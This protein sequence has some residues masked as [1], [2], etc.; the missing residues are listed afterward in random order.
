MA[1]ILDADTTLQHSAINEACD[2]DCHELHNEQVSEGDSDCDV[3]DGPDDGCPNAESDSEEPVEDNEEDSL[4]FEAIQKIERLALSFLEQLAGSLR[5]PRADI[6]YTRSSPAA[7]NTRL[8]YSKIELQLADRHKTSS[9]C[10]R[11]IRYPLKRRGA[12][13]KPFGWSGSRFMTASFSPN[14]RSNIAQ[15]LRVMDFAHQAL[16]DNVPLTKRDMYYKDV[17]LFKAQGTV[18]RLVDDLAV[19]LG[20]ER[21]D[22]KIRAASKGLICG[23]GLTIHLLEGDV[24]SINDLEG[25]LIPTGETIERFELKGDI[26]WVL[27][28]EKEAVFQTLCRFQFASHRSLSGPGLIITGKGY[29]DVATR[30]LVKTLSDNLPAHIPIVALVDG[31]AYGLDILSVYKYGSRSLRHENKKLA[32]KRIEWLGIWAS[33]IAD[34]E[35]DLDTLIPITLHDEKKAL[36]VLSRPTDVVPTK[37]RQVQKELTRMLHIRR[38]AE[39]EILSSSSSQKSNSL[40]HYL[41]H[42][43]CHF[44]E[45]SA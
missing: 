31:D 39:I 15:I 14:G 27:V 5:N 10:T 45:M 24:I 23:T 43:I 26:S 30:Q 7:I 29:P 33:E 21:A 9:E 4:R 13:I 40:I 34:L 35:I 1:S 37:W 41:V 32:A 28:V 12:S 22:L 11:V 17:P 19:T 16:V 36:A 42:K 20:L 38:K 3:S 44:I 2:E 6:A 25:T 8:K 18:D